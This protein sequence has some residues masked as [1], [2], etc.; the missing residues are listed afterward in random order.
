MMLSHGNADLDAGFEFKGDVIIVDRHPLKELPDKIIVVFL[1]IRLLGFQKSL[2]LIE[3]PLDACVVGILQ[4]E[5]LFRI[6]HGIEL[7]KNIGVV[8]LGVRPFEQFLFQI[9]KLGIDLGHPCSVTG[10]ECLLN[11]DLEPRKQIVLL[12][13]HLIDGLDHRSM[14]IRFVK[15]PRRTVYFAFLPVQPA[16]APPDR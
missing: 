7:L 16:C 4:K 1:N 12:G 10:T 3:V 8:L 5:L 11:G 15:G 6:T 13:D 2:D 9:L 14:K